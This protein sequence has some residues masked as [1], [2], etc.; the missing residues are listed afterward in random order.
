MKIKEGESIFIEELAVPS[1]LIKDKRAKENQFQSDSSFNASS[2]SSISIFSSTSSHAS[3]ENDSLDVQSQNSYD[4]LNYHLLI[5]DTNRI[6]NYDSDSTAKSESTYDSNNIFL[7]G[8]YNNMIDEQND[9][10]RADQK[11]L[12]YDITRSIASHFLMNNYFKILNRRI[13][14]NKNARTSFLLQQLVTSHSNPTVS[15]LYPESMLFSS[16]FLQKCI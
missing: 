12:L 8:N 7:A 14:I 5:E 11:V 13:A 16:I 2:Q 9:K 1:S 10:A 6:L 3:R 4:S 15:L